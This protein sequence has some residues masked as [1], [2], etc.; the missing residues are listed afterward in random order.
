VDDVDIPLKRGVRSI[1]AELEG[2]TSSDKAFGSIRHDQ[3]REEMIDKIKL[4]S[5]GSEL[6]IG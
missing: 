2:G 5:V 1:N 6:E 3:A 4:E